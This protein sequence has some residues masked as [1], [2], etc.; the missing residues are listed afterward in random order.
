MA[1][2]KA[3][4]SPWAIK[5]IKRASLLPEDELALSSEI[6]IMEKVGHFAIT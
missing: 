2:C 4:H 6:A 1:T 3:D 5:I